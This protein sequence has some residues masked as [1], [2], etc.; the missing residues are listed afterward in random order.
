MFIDGL[1]DYANVAMDF[2]HFERWIAPGGFVAFHDYATYY[3]GVV[4]FVD[5]LVNSSSYRLLVVQKSL[6]LV[7]KLPIPERRFGAA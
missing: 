7:Q 2:H 6:A 1:H 5:E 3:P 4:T